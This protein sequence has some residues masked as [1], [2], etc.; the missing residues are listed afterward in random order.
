MATDRL[1]ECLSEMENNF[2]IQVIGDESEPAYNRIMLSSVLATEKSA[3]DIQLKQ[4]AWYKK[5]DISIA[6][7][8]PVVDIDL[9][10]QQVTTKSADFVVTC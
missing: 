8:D 6:Y 10:N 2:S 1:L 4:A 9:D 7:G 3:A 5:Q